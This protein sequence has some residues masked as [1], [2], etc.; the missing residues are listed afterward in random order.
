LGRIY[1]ERP[2]TSA[3]RSQRYRDAHPGR[4]TENMG[5]WRQKVQK[6]QPE[7]WRKIVVENRRRIKASSVMKDYGLTIDEYKDLVS[8]PCGLCGRTDIRRVPD[9]NHKTKVIRGPLCI[10]HNIKVGQLES[11]I[12]EGLLGKAL[13][14]LKK[15]SI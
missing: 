5:K 7:R 4:A 6:E 8:K 3:E 9:H 12:R 2:L 11:L 13:E 1:S 15:P 10:A 14:W